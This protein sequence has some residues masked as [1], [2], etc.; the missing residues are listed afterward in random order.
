MVSHLAQRVRK[1]SRSV[2]MT[3][4]GILVRTFI[5]QIATG[6][7]EGKAWLRAQFEKGVIR[8]CRP[9]GYR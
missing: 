5:F 9:L 7:I 3:H 6:A 2:A 4:T 1:A 8:T